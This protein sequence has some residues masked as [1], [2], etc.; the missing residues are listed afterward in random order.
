MKNLLFLILIVL[1][2]ALYAAP[3]LTRP[4]T[5]GNM[6]TRSRFYDASGRSLGS[7]RTYNYGGSVRTYYYDRGGRYTGYDIQLNNLKRK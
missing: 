1:S 3:P 4:S 5:P 2:S 7:A 6:A